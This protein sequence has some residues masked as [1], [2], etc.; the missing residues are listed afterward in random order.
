MSDNDNRSTCQEAT[1]PAGVDEAYRAAVEEAGLPPEALPAIRSS[2]PP[3]SARSIAPAPRRS[4]LPALPPWVPPSHR[5]RLRQALSTRPRLPRRAD[6]SSSSKAAFDVEA[7]NALQARR[8]AAR[9]AGEDLP[10]L[11]I[12]VLISGSGT[13]LQALID[14]IASGN[15]NAE[16]VLVGQ[17]R[18]RRAQMSR[19]RQESRPL[20]SPKRSTPIPGTP[21]RSSPPSSSARARSTS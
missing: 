13:N 18:V 14:E 2:R 20:R 15:L 17:G 21:M 5:K 4:P 9:A 19:R 3:L 12:G 11:K 8:A 1:A 16:I 10:P 7:G 6:A